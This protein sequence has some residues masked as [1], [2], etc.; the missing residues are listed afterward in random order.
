[1]NTP[2]HFRFLID[3]VET[4]AREVPSLLY[5]ESLTFWDDLLETCDHRDD[6]RS[7]WIFCTRWIRESLLEVMQSG[8]ARALRGVLG[9]LKP[10][11]EVIDAESAAGKRRTIAHLL[12]ILMIETLSRVEIATEHRFGERYEDAPPSYH[13]GEQ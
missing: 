9:V 2:L 3:H 13:P 11:V 12:P 10:G 4:A 1:M 7:Y 8:T 6:N 5:S